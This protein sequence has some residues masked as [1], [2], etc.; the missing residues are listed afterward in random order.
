MNSS[1]NANTNSD[2]S[3]NRFSLLLLLLFLTTTL[4][5]AD[6]YTKTIDQTFAAVQEVAFAQRNGHLEILPAT[7][8]KIRLVAQ[9]SINATD[10][11]EA[12]RFLERAELYATATATTL[13]LRLA[14]H[15][16]TSWITTGS[17]SVV[18]FTDGEKIRGVRDFDV[19]A[20]LYLPPTQLLELASQFSDINIANQVTL[21]NLTLELNNVD[22][23]GGVVAGDLKVDARFGS[24]RLE[25]AAGQ[26]TGKLNNGRLKIDR[27][28]G[29][30]NLNTRFSDLELGPMQNVELISSN[31]KVDIETV[32]GQLQLNERFGK[33]RLGTTGSADIISSNGDYTVRQGDTYTINGRFTTIDFDEVKVLVLTANSNCTYLAER[34]DEVRGDGRFTDIRVDRFTGRAELDLTNGE[35]RVDELAPSFTGIRVDGR[36]FDVDVRLA[37]A[38]PYQA[39]AKLTFGHFDVPGEMTSRIDKERSNEMEKHFLSKGATAASPTIEVSGTNSSLRIN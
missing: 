30:L 31:D 35:F 11:G 9:L 21:N 20:T 5:A 24:I 28:G 1:S 39:K 17:R 12:Q 36:F 4:G 19:R 18:K 6:P 26:I 10:E 23:S 22:L 14:L 29:N 16:I 13:N 38:M 25:S 33:Y 34:L 2:A 7:N 3:G 27:G 37:G 15:D 8:G 32:S